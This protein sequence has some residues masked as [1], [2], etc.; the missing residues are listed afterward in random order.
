[1]SKDRF[2]NPLSESQQVVLRQI[3]E[4]LLRGLPVEDQ[5]A[6]VEIAGKPVLLVSAGVDG[7]AELEFS[8]I[9]VAGETCFHTIWVACDLL[10]AAA[11]A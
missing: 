8:E 3:P 10:E 7:L 11:T 9:R 1:M 4:D 2:G 5:Q 6:I